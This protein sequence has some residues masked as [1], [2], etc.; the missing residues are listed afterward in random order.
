MVH[1]I[2]CN[3]I[4]LVYKNL[5]TLF[6]INLF[7]DNGFVTV[8]VLEHLA[9]LWFQIMLG[10]AGLNVKSGSGLWIR[11][12]TWFATTRIME[13]IFRRNDTDIIGFYDLI[14]G[15]YTL[16]P[17]NY[18]FLKEVFDNSPLHYDDGYRKYN[19]FKHWMPRNVGVA[20]FTT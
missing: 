11:Q 5:L 20:P 4:V 18:E 12:R 17:L 3:F 6:G 2:V 1:S 15:E 9:I 10:I 16:F 8:S 19:L 14:S 7:P 13:Y